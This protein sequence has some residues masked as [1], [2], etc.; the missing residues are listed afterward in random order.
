MLQPQRGI[1]EPTPSLKCRFCASVNACFQ[2][3]PSDLAFGT[4]RTMGENMRCW[5]RDRRIKSFFDGV[6]CESL[7]EGAQSMMQLSGLGKLRP[8]ILF[9]GFKRNWADKGPEGMDDLNEYFGVIQ[10][11]LISS[12]TA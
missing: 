4:I 10:Y 1:P 6:A 2:C 7:R 12:L 8:N 5:L 3:K 11:V 9:L